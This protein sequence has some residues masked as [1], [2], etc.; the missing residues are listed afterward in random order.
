MSAKA[1]YKPYR[2]LAALEKTGST[3]RVLNLGA[4]ARAHGH[5]AEHATTPLLRSPVLNRALVLKHR[6][7]AEDGDVAGALH[8]RGSATKVIVPF[9][10]S[11]LSLGGSA[12]F[13]GQ[14]GWVE[15]LAQ[16]G[17]PS[18]RADLEH[19]RIVLEALDEI[20]S[21]DPFLVREHLR[22]KELRVADCYFDLPQADMERMQGFVTREVSPLVG[23]VYGSGARSHSSAAKLARLL[24]STRPDQRLHLLGRTLRLD[25]P[26][27][28]EG[29][30]AWKGF[31][32]YKWVLGSLMNPLQEVVTEIGRLQVLGAHGAEAAGLIATA[33]SRLQATI[34]TRSTEARNLIRRYDQ[35][36]VRLTRNADT[37][38]FREFLLASP[39][40]FLEL[41]ERTGVLSHVASFWR[42]RFPVD[43]VPAAQVEEVIDLFQE[44]EASLAQAPVYLD[45]A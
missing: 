37:R 9:E 17:G 21:L 32:Y 11:N 35:A 41:G 39:G 43:S 10:R 15:M 29:V 12:L 45:A 4:I 31:L 38:T 5:L 6:L 25:G 24:L 16:L 7:R 34:Q 14:P 1:F 23:L 44:F 33:R 8:R 3:S 40:L 28:A 27:Y 22:S 36:F 20:P 30:H 19:D 18:G 26:S 2:S 42:F 13:V